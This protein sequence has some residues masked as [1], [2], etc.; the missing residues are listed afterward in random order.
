MKELLPDPR[1]DKI[2]TAV[3]ELVRGRTNSVGTVTLTNGVATTTV[4]DEDVSPTSRIFLSPQT[5]AAA[6]ENWWIDNVTFGSFRINHANAATTR[7]FGYLIST[8]DS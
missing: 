6:G 7:T 3:N 2:R 5:S 1:P 4:E 8:G